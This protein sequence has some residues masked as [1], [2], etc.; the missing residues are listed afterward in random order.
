MFCFLAASTRGYSTKAAVAVAVAAFSIRFN[1][2]LPS[3]ESFLSP[4]IHLIEFQSFFPVD[5]GLCSMFLSVD[6][7]AHSTSQFLPCCCCFSLLFE[8]I[9]DHFYALHNLYI[10]WHLKWNLVAHFSTT[11]P[12]SNSQFRIAPRQKTHTHRHSEWTY[13]QPTAPNDKFQR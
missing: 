6:I 12:I 1:V 10:V 11:Q 7:L 13:G 9:Y 5:T 8:F 4:L 3:L 2:I